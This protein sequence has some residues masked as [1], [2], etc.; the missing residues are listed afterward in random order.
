MPWLIRAALNAGHTRLAEAVA[1][2]AGARV[3]QSRIPVPHCRRGPRPGPGRAGYQALLAEAAALHPD[4]WSRASAA[5]DLGVYHARRADRRR[6]VRRLA[7][8]NQGYESIGA[9]AD[10]AR[11]RRRLRHL[12]VRR[13]HWT[14]S[15]GRPDRG[16]ESLTETQHTVSELTA[17][18]LNNRQ[19]A[20]GMYVSS[21][22]W[23][24]T[25]ARY[26]V[27]SISAHGLNSPALSSSGDTTDRAELSGH[28]SVRIEQ[29]NSCRPAIAARQ[30]I[31]AQDAIRNSMSPMN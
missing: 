23:P 29:E 30:G 16:W 28:Q 7:E 25:C 19:I 9:T 20:A 14:Q 4:P 22:R 6:A 31:H 13:R 26:S 18:G 2:G 12:G 10:T 17:Q 24:S 27:S 8:A 5:E 3:G 21:T 11:V 1:R 15:P